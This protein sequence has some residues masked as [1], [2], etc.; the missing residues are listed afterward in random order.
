MIFKY[1]MV[2]ERKPHCADCG[3]RIEG[4]GSILD[5]YFCHNCGLFQFNSDL[6]EYELVRL[7]NNP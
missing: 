5:P 1:K 4:N 2:K 7:K 3:G 6:M